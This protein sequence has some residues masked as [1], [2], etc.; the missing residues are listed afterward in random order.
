M[1]RGPGSKVYIICDT[2]TT[3]TVQFGL[4]LASSGKSSTFSIKGIGPS[5]MKKAAR[6]TMRLAKGRK[7]IFSNIE[8][9]EVRIL[10]DVAKYSVV[11]A[12]DVVISVPLFDPLWHSSKFSFKRKNTATPIIERQMKISDMISNTLLPNLSIHTVVATDPMT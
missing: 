10:V 7:P 11:V 6:K 8:V 3:N 2:L 4:T 5:P 1:R 9:V 12:K